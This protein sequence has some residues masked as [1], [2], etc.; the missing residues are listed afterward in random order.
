MY[1]DEMILLQFA[2][3]VTQAQ[4]AE[5]IRG[6]FSIFKIRWNAW[7]CKNLRNALIFVLQPQQIA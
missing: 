2:S 5:E 6:P 3:S 1:D 4:G 7:R